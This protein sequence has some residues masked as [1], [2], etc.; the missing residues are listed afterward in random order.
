MRI[1][2]RVLFG[3]AGLPLV[4]AT[5]RTG[6]GPTTQDWQA[7]AA[8]LDGSLERPG[9]AGYDPARRLFDP[10]FDGVRP[11][12]I[13]R[14]TGPADVVE[15]LAFARRFGVPVVARGGGHSYVG[16]STSGTSLVLDLRRMSAVAYDAAGRTAAIGGGARLIDVYDALGAHRVSVPA[17]SCG[18]VGIGGITL[19]GGIG[20]GASAY[21][22]TCDTVLSADVVTAD[23]RHRTVDAT[24]EPALFWAL[25]GGG[26][27]QFGVVT[28]WRMRTHPV[29]TVGS[30][31]LTYPWRD[32]A[33]VAAGWQARLATAPDQT[34]SACQFAADGRGRR[35]VRISGFVLD[36]DADGE[37]AAIVRAIR[38]EPASC[39]V[40]RRAHLDVV[41]DRAG[42]DESGD[43]GDRSTELV[44]SD[45][46]RQALPAS[47]IAAL[48]AAVDRRARARRPGVAKFKRM[49]GAVARVPVGATAFPWRG[50][51]TMLQWL[52]K[53]SAGDAATVRDAYAWIDDGHRAVAPWS[54]GRYV[55]YLEPGAALLPRYHGPHLDR[56]RRIRA[57]VDPDRVFRSAYAL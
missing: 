42:C 32:A 46:F 2:R 20:M 48:L 25:R 26:G 11:P 13:A 16:A 6:H 39:A 49:T 35:T 28:R 45:V 10:R 21:G 52:V 44:G 41:H 1:S 14:C 5:T 54:A 43:C 23:G 29:S 18:T 17:G 4:A 40:D 37:V 47:A 19:G 36:D 7:L 22:L 57:V 51:H 12:A 27:G 56:L 8:G 3:A 50:A 55:N 34:W 30:F 38:R 33:A 24:R 15:V 31:V 9:S 53:P